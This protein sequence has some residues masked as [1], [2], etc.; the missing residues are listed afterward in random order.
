[1]EQISELQ[2]NCF[3]HTNTGTLEMQE[4]ARVLLSNTTPARCPRPMEYL[5]VLQQSR[6]SFYKSASQ[7]QQRGNSAVMNSAPP[8]PPDNISLGTKGITQQTIDF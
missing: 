7:S 5:T 6:V 4:R 2:R 1:M 3:G 8:A